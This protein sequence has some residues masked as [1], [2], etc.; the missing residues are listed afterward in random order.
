MDDS[1]VREWLLAWRAAEYDPADDDV[2]TPLRGVPFG[3]DEVLIVLRWKLSRLWPKK[4]EAMFR[5]GVDQARVM[6]VSARAFAARNPTTALAEI[7]SLPAVGPAV[8]S[9]VLMAHDPGRY[10]VMDVKALASLRALDLLPEGPPTLSAKR[11]FELWPDYL[12]SC[13]KLATSTE[14]DLREVDH[15]LWAANGRTTL[16]DAR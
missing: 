11:W 14:L 7:C 5:A 8:G 10:T 3:I 13:R 4:H 15:G 1:R 12:A 6:V 9:A 16:P 2:L